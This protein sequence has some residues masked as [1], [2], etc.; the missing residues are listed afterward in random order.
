MFIAVSNDVL[1]GIALFVLYGRLCAEMS[2]RS[3]LAW[4]LTGFSGTAGAATTAEVATSLVQPDTA[5]DALLQRNDEAA[6]TVNG[7]M[8]AGA[9]GWSAIGQSAGLA[10]LRA[11]APPGVLL[12]ILGEVFGVS[13]ARLFAGFAPFAILVGFLLLLMAAPAV[14]SGR[15]AVAT[16]EIE[17][18]ALAWM[19][20]PFIV[21][22]VIGLGYAT[23]TEAG[24]LAV[25]VHI[26][27][28]PNGSCRAKGCSGRFSIRCRT[29]ARSSSS[30]CSPIACRRL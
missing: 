19:A 21:L 27:H 10:F 16:S 30:W 14:S 3:R 11:I 13:I 8:L 15:Q 4:A 18:G 25:G 5:G 1:I 7:L 2:V 9:P 24:A 29:R 12:I 22:G 20:V 23:P 17:G 26:R 6:A 28:L